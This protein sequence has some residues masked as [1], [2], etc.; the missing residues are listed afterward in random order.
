MAAVSVLVALYMSAPVGLTFLLIIVLGFALSFAATLAAKLTRAVTITAVSNTPALYK[1]ESAKFTVTVFNR[2]I[3]P[4][5]DLQVKLFTPDGGELLRFSV[6]GKREHSFTVEF[7]AEHWGQY[8]LGIESVKMGD[9]LGIFSLNYPVELTPEIIAVFPNIAEIPADDEVF[10]GAVG[11]MWDNPEEETTAQN[12]LTF[13]GFPGYN[14]REYVPGDPV[15]RINRKLSAKR[16]VLML[17]LDDENEIRS[18]KI[19]LSPLSE[20]DNL[21]REEAA[22]EAVLG[23]AKAFV[24]LDMTADVYIFDEIFTKHE[25]K[26]EAAVKELQTYFAGYKFSREEALPEDL[27]GM[28]IITAF[29]PPKFVDDGS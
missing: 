26:D 8:K 2:T 21:V 23:Y 18:A 17:R 9:F 3:L 13:S 11:A 4:V 22:L 16:G 20:D 28:I 5:P 10:G 7:T 27:Q 19:V 6:A 24:S 14:H 12:S 29:D 1:G 15:K 25:C